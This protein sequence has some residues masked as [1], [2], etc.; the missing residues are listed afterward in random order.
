MRKAIFISKDNI[1]IFL[2]EGNISSYGNQYS[3]TNGI[4][5][6]EGNSPYRGKL[7]WNNIPNNIREEE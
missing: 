1:P 3:L 7:F 5:H 6:T 2:I 4:F